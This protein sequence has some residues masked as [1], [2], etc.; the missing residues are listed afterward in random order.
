MN[1]VIKYFSGLFKAFDIYYANE[2]NIVVSCVLGRMIIS[3]LMLGFF[4]NIA[5]FYGILPILP[6]KLF[7]LHFQRKWSIQAVWHYR[8]I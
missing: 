8:C 5:L 1:T 4:T 3:K 7:Y 6:I 2:V